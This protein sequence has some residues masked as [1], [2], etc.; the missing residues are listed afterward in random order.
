MYR[1]FVLTLA[2]LFGATLFVPAPAWAWGEAGHVIV[3]KV[4]EQYLNPKARD[5]V[6]DLLD[7]RPLSDPR[8]VT[9]ADA[10]KGSAAM[11]RK[12]PG[13]RT[14]HYVDID[15]KLEEK[16]FKPLDEKDNVVAAIERAKKDLVDA[17]KSKEDRKEA[18]LFIIH[19]VGDMHQP[20]HCCERNKDKGGNLVKVKSFQGKEE[21]K[22]NLHLIW[23]VHLVDATRGKLEPA[24]FAAR[25]IE[26]IKDDDRAAWNKGDTRAWAWE[27]HQVALA[28][29]YKFTDGKEVPT[30]ENAV[31]ELTDDNYVKANTK[32]V[33]EQLKRAGV[34]LAKVLND[35]FP[36]P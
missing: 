26:E 21:A 1:R 19:F 15:V 29:V 23:D 32:V 13:Q 9:W 6:K 34:R 14:W 33:A 20:L 24:D 12:Y 30:D 18:L 16:D 17:G 5:A 4:A 7:D 35:A 11:E 31:I 10:I 22:L 25:L 36:A 8:L 28:S 3:A 27:V 2:V